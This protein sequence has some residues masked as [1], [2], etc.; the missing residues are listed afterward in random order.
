MNAAQLTATIESSIMVIALVVLSLKIVPGSRL[1][2]FRQ[3][4]F[5]LRDELFDYAAAGN[6]HF[7][8]PAYRLLRQ[9]M[10]GYIRYAHQLTFFR[11]CMLT[12]ERKVF[13]IEEKTTWHDKWEASLANIENQEIKDRLCEFHMRSSVLAIRRVV[14]GSPLVLLSFV[15]VA[16]TLMIRDGWHNAKRVLNRAAEATLSKIVSTHSIEEDAAACAV[17]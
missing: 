5:A 15:A 2:T 12:I 8:D 4:M 14:N 16:I 1:L 9:S 7:N 10:N 17:A 11:L 6:I 13:G 3:D